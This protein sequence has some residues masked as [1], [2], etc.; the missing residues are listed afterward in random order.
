[1]ARSAITTELADRLKALP[2]Y[3]FVQ[4][5]ELKKAMLAKGV[6]VVDLG[7]GDPD[8]PTPGPVVEACARAARDPANHQY[9]TN[10]GLAEFREAAAAWMQDRYGVTCDSAGVLPVLG[11]KEAIG[12]IA[13]AFVNPGDTVLVPDPC[14]PV[15]RSATILADAAYHSMPLVEKNGFLPDYGEIPAEVCRRARLMYLNYPNNP[16]GAVADEAFFE[17]TVEFAKANDIIV[18]HD[19]AYLE[20]AYDGY[21]PPSFLA[22]EGAGDVGVEFHSLSKTFNMTGWR[23]GWA[24]GNA[25]IVAGLMKVKSNIDSGMFQALQLCAVEALRGDLSSWRAELTALYT[26]R[27]D[28]LCDGLNAMGWRVEKPKASFYVW[29]RVPEGMTS[30]DVAA[31]LLE[32]GGVVVIPGNGYGDAG[33]GYVRMGLTLAS[34]RIEEAVRRIEP[35]YKRWRSK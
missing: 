7:I 19:A 28:I 1:M 25:E 9:P 8:T 26:E 5:D 34:E 29:A 12:H 24:T 3:L 14:Y 10:W 30:A 17:R 6:D 2:P 21:K 32:H 23:I 35:V 13:L 4:I 27:R 31:G 22:V 18:V 20:V 16:T 33:E 11:S 15:Y